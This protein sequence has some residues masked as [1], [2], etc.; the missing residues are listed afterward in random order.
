ML[1]LLR[2]SPQPLVIRLTP[3][4][5]FPPPLEPPT[6]TNIQLPNLH[7]PSAVIGIRIQT[8]LQDQPDDISDPAQRRRRRLVAID[9]DGDGTSARIPPMR[10]GET[11][12]LRE[13]HRRSHLVA[14]VHELQRRHAVDQLREHGRDG[15]LADPAAHLVHCRRRERG[16]GSEVVDG[17]VGLRGRGVGGALD[18]ER[19]RAHVLVHVV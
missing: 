2:S 17:D 10:H 7:H 4:K 18:G 1:L 19:K 3:D 12:V 13:H 11:A 8:M 14:V 16:D 9:L 5:A 15:H 6:H